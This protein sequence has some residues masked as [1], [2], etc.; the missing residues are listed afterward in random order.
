[1]LDRHDALIPQ[2]GSFPRYT[3]QPDGVRPTAGPILY[4]HVIEVS[5]TAM[6]RVLDSRLNPPNHLTD[7]FVW[8]REL[9]GTLSAKTTVWEDG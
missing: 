6:L 8:V 7:T 4:P 9:D 1:M 5:P 3:N 2:D